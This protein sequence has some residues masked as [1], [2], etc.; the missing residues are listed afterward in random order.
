MLPTASF[1]GNVVKLI[2]IWLIYT[3]LTVYIQSTPHIIPISLIKL[4][5]R[6]RSPGATVGPRDFIDGSIPR[7]PYSPSPLNYREGQLSV[8]QLLDHCATARSRR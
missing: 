7:A 5:C 6:E 1:F 4:G 2:G 3:C 8:Q